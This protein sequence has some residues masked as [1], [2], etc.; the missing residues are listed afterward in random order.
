MKTIF[1]LSFCF[2][3]GFT[4]A[5]FTL[6]ADYPFTSDGVDLISGDEAY[7]S[8]ATF[9]E[10]GIYSNGIYAG[11]DLENG[12]EIRTGSVEN[13]E[14]SNFKFTLEFRVDSLPEQSWMPIIVGGPSW[15]WAAVTVQSDGLLAF[16]GNVGGQQQVSGQQ[17]PLGMWHSLEVEY[18]GSAL[19][20]LLNETEA[21]NISID[22]LVDGEDNRFTCSHNGIGKNFKGY[23]R[24]LKVYSPVT[25]GGEE[26][27]ESSG[28][29]YPNPA[30]EQIQLSGWGSESESK[31]I[32]L[33]DVDGKVVRVYTLQTDPATLDVSGI[34]PGVY[35]LR[36]E[37]ETEKIKRLV[38]K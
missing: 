37:D 22:E 9:A 33:I 25:V 20:V 27:E 11:N 23:W 17:V 6:L 26:A 19:I 38:V 15:R 31:E 24:N 30:T 36:S 8:N 34:K 1:T 2:V 5:Q 16:R 21:I 28:V 29:I 32:Q 18:N 4:Q 14:F 3:F 10:G 13:F 12:T 35:L 7:L